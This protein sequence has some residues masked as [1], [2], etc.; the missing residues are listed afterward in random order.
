MSIAT[1]CGKTK[2]QKKKKQPRETKI[3]VADVVLVALVPR[4][5][6]PPAAVIYAA[7][8]QELDKAVAEMLQLLETSG[9]WGKLWGG[10][11]G[12]GWGGEYGE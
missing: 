10:G 11:V 12:G 7:Q 8:A 1:F 5:I 4:P 9:C 6:L 3:N 2:N